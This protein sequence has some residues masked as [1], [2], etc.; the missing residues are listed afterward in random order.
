MST[1]LMNRR[2]R[3]KLHI[4]AAKK[5]YIETSRAIHARP[6]IGNEEFFASQTLTKILEDA[7]FEVSWNI[8]GHETGFVARK[9]SSKPGPK[10]AILPNT[11]L[12][13]GLATPAAII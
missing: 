6:E 11:T 7:G 4:E 12:C 5:R 9:G 2:E 8:A 10:S 3:I 1:V 13:P